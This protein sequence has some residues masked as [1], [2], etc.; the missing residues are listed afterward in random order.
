VIA[1]PEYGSFF[2]ELDACRLLNDYDCGL[3]IIGSRKVIKDIY[4]K[5]PNL[6]VVQ[7]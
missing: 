3:G 7:L 2:Y 6:K 4:N 5:F 1:F